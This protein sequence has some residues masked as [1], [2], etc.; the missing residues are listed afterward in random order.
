[1]KFQ[2]P[3]DKSV[4]MTLGRASAIFVAAAAVSAGSLLTS[5]AEQSAS[6]A[7]TDIAH[8]QVPSWSKDDLNFFLHGSMSTEVVP[9]AVLRAFIKTYPDLFPTSDL[10]YLGMIPDKD[11]GWPIGFSRRNVQ[12]LGGMSAIWINCASCHVAQISSISYSQPIQILG[13]T[14]H[15]NVEGFF[16]SVLVATF[17]TSDPEN[18]KRFLRNYV[19]DTEKVHGDHA[20]TVVN[21][22]WKKQEE[23]ILAVMKTDP[24]GANDGAPD[25]LHKIEPADA[26]LGYQIARQRRCR[27]CS[28][29]SLD[30]PTLPQ[31]ARGAA[32]SG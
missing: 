5:T 6:F 28:S 16:G 2:P 32:R 11:F 13:V 10:T 29:R 4:A 7:R 8:Q 25:D 22:A 19:S 15:F 18:M 1:L 26:K 23:K 20:E 9:E 24:F 17:K 3:L 14:S 27:S 31:H 21:A 12:H 30:A